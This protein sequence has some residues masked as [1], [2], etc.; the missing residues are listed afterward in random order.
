MIKNIESTT[1]LIKIIDHKKQYHFQ[2]VDLSEVEDETNKNYKY[3]SNVLM[4]IR[5]DN[6]SYTK[7]LPFP[8][9]IF[10]NTCF[11]NQ[12]NGVKYLVNENITCLR[13]LSK[14]ICN[15]DGPLSLKSFLVDDPSLNISLKDIP[16]IRTNFNKAEYL[17]ATFKILCISNGWQYLRFSRI[18]FPNFSEKFPKENISL[19]DCTKEGLL[20]P[21]YYDD[22]CENVVL[23]VSYDFKWKASSVT[24]LKITI[25]LGNIPMTL[26][27]YKSTQN[28]Y[29][30]ENS[31]TSLYKVRESE[32]VIYLCQT[33]ITNF[34]HA[35]N[36]TD[37]TLPK[38]NINYVGGY[39]LGDTVPILIKKTDKRFTSDS[40]RNKSSKI[41][42]S[43]KNNSSTTQHLENFLA[44]HSGELKSFLFLQFSI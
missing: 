15:S 33:F 28:K 14:N 10:P 12:S 3:G 2:D 25:V 22:L 5:L 17:N 9:K 18:K 31:L 20:E 6:I 1:K 8:Q 16:R 38:K 36:L 24:E 41:E 30:F 11:E 29:L 21:F 4:D 44:W 13:R 26:E 27:T 35:Y 43:Q 39:D 19:V 34:I 42:N 7:P 32:A 23:S 37:E 40:S